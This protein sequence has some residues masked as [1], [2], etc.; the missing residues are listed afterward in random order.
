MT[1][2]DTFID[3]TAATQLAAAQ[4]AAAQLAAAQVAAAQRKRVELDGR[5][6]IAICSFCND[7][8]SLLD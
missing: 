4:P 8:S 1:P 3:D 7:V 2:N 6:E 5:R